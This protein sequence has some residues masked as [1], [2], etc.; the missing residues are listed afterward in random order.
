MQAGQLTHKIII[1][2]DASDGTT[3]EKDWQTLCEVWA[4]KKGLTGRLFYEAAAA[5]SENEVIFTIRHRT[6]IK[7][8][9]QIILD[10]NVASPYRIT[11]EPVD[12]ADGHQWLEIH[13]ERIDTNGG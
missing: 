10:G 6:G 5:Q 8:T 9:M 4:A 12:V 11:S 13:A 3:D 1:K 2:Y 7:P